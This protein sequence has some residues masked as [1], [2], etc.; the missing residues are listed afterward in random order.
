MLAGGACTFMLVKVWASA[1]VFVLETRAPFGS[2]FVGTGSLV[3]VIFTR[4]SGGAERA[5]DCC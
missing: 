5:V 1:L 4:G 3:G 2:E